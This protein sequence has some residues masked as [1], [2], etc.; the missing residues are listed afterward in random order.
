[1]YGNLNGLTKAGNDVRHQQSPTRGSG[2]QPGTLTKSGDSQ[3][4]AMGL[5]RQCIMLTP[6]AQARFKIKKENDNGSKKEQRQKRFKSQSGQVEAY[7]RDGQKPDQ[8][9]G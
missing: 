8:N 9:R 1:V 2:R 3:F 5:T 7:E 6:A 4:N